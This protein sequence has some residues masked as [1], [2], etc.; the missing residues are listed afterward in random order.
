MAFVYITLPVFSQTSNI[1]LFVCAP[2]QVEDIPE[3]SMNYLLN[4]LCT[5]V[6][7]E[8][9][10][11]QSD[12]LTQFLLVPH[13]SV[14]DK[15]VLANTQQQIV[16]TLD[17]ALKIIDNLTG[18]IYASKTITIKGTGINA[19]KAYNSAFR[20]I[21]KQNSH[22][23]DL[24]SSANKKI[25]DFYEAES[26]NIIKRANL[27]AIQENYEEAFYMLSM[28]PSQCSKYDLGISAGLSIWEK[29]KDYSC[30]KNLAKARSIW[31]AE[32]SPNSAKIAGSYL[33][34]IL[35]D[36]SCYDDA[37]QLSK[38][39]KRKIGDIWNF[40]MKQYETDASLKKA[41]IDAIRAIGVAYGKEQK[42]QF[43][44]YRTKR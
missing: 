13:V 8:G 14:T 11:A 43:A 24:I 22:I 28:I 18:T 36:S 37:L 32:Q 12:Y 15:H 16:L 4:T 31:L 34:K 26:E 29:Y 2:E 41:K 10:A 38:E 30:Y 25:L 17:V 21:N 33:A 23:K 27:L 6:T 42:Y 3:P 5:V 20:T 40:E 1:Q 44:F 9:L 7:S 39:I 19:T 35:P